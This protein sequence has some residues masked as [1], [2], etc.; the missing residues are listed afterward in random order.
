MSWPKISTFHMTWF[1][2]RFKGGCT[3]NVASMWQNCNKQ[4]NKFLGTLQK[5]IPPP[6]NLCPN[7]FRDYHC[8]LPN[9]ITVTWQALFNTLY[10]QIII[11]YLRM[12]KARMNYCLLY[13]QTYIAKNLFA[14]LSGISK[15]FSPSFKLRSKNDSSP[16]HMTDAC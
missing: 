12:A 16:P 2:N 11:F 9:I 15:I 4:R 10:N 6:S 8:K 5:S 7:Y 14:L 13:R 3:G 1:T